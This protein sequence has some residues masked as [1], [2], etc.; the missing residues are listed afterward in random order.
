MAGLEVYCLLKC[1]NQGQQAWKGG[2][3]EGVACQITAGKGALNVVGE[4][5]C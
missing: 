5:G 2:S 4:L 1:G 3:V